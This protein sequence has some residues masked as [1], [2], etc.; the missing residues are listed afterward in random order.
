MGIIGM[1]GFVEQDVSEGAAR[2]VAQPYSA[3]MAIVLLMAFAPLV[4][5]SFAC[6]VCA[7]YRLTKER[8]SEVMAAIGSGNADERAVVLAEL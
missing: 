5:M 4:F 2:V 6:F 7:R 1:A 8:H 3:Q